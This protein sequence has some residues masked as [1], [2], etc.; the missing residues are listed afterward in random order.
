MALIGSYISQD[1]FISV[2]NVLREYDDM[3]Q[4]IKNL[5]SS[6]KSLIYL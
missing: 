6:S 4:A 5:N 3:K 1:E 2:I